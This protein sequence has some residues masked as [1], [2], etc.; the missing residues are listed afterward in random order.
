MALCDTKTLDDSKVKSS[1]T[2]ED[3]VPDGDSHAST[4]IPAP[5][6]SFYDDAAIDHDGSNTVEQAKSVSKPDSQLGRAKK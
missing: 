2:A 6:T 3:L 1:V 5:S 4:S